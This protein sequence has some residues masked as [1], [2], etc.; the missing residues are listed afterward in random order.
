MITVIV[1]G[2]EKRV[3]VGTTFG[4]LL[5]AMGIYSLGKNEMM[6][7]RRSPFGKEVPLYFE[8]DIISDMP[9]M[10]GDRIEG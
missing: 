1:N 9:L 4:K 6:W 5:H 8:G 3:P 7:Y 10:H 2:V